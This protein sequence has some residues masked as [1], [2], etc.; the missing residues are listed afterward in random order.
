MKRREFITLIG[1]A[2]AW[3]LIAHAQQSAMPVIGFLSGASPD[4]FAHLAAAFR[5][6]QSG[7]RWLFASA[8]L[9]GKPLNEFQYRP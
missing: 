6:G 9:L 7:G 4:P 1:G 8:D 5:Q 2:A 3:P